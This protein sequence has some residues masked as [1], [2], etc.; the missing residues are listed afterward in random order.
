MSETTCNSYP[1]YVHTNVV[2]VSDLVEQLREIVDHPFDVVYN[3]QNLRNQLSEI[4]NQV[5]PLRFHLNDAQK[6]L[7]GSSIALET[8]F[9]SEIAN[10]DDETLRANIKVRQESAVFEEEWR[11]MNDERFAAEQTMSDLLTSKSASDNRIDVLEKALAAEK[12][13]AKEIETELE[14]SR[15]RYWQLLGRITSGLEMR[16]RLQQS[17]VEAEEKYKHAMLMKEKMVAC[18]GKIRAFWSW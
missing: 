13:K 14:A 9:L 4:L 10:I 7:V 5:R 12:V 6:G 18:W 11:L 2:K 3:D 16:T 15:E 8:M 1:R 17:L